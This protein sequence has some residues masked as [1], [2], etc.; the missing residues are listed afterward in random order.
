MSFTEASA[1]FDKQHHPPLVLFTW[2]EQLY[3]INMFIM[4]RK[5]ILK[6]GDIKFVKF[7]TGKWSEA[8][9]NNSFITVHQLLTKQNPGICKRQYSNKRVNVRHDMWVDYML[10]DKNIN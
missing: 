3:V 6:T 7:V 1:K 5:V 4:N 9:A 10:L 8:K 2:Q